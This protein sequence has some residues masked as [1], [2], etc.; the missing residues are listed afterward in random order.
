M[1]PEDLNNGLM[2]IQCLCLTVALQEGD[3]ALN[4]AIKMPGLRQNGLM[5]GLVRLL[6]DEGTDPTVKDIVS[7]INQNN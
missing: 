3:T 4:L 2:L 7:L 5:A 6:R 1:L